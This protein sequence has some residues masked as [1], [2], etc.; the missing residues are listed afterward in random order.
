MISSSRA[1]YLNARSTLRT[2]LKLG[3]MPVINEND[4][5]AT[6]ELRFGDNDTLAALVANLIEADLLILL[7]DQDGLFDQDPRKSSRRPSSLPQT[8]V[9]D[10][11]LD[12]GC[13]RQRHRALAPAAW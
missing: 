3:V 12:R 13:W 4:T 7:T 1:R 6:D 9:N 5:V 8:R 10:P 11:Q 2:L